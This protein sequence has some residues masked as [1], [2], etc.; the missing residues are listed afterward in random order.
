MTNTFILVNN[1]KWS[2]Y[3]KYRLVQL[4]TYRTIHKF[5]VIVLIVFFYNHGCISKLKLKS[6]QLFLTKWIIFAQ[7]QFLS[8]TVPLG[9][10]AVS[11]PCSTHHL[12]QNSPG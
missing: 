11:R 6:A 12:H 9:I 10:E 8:E 3:V 1:F 5:H 2:L 7:N 4:K